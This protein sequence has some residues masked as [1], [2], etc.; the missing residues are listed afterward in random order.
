MKTA[1]TAIAICKYQQKPQANDLII[2]WIIYNEKKKINQNS[3]GNSP[4]SNSV[5]FFYMEIE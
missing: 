2:L 4:F 1:F 3:Y 5:W